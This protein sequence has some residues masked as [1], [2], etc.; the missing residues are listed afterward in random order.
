[1]ANTH[2][3]GD[4]VPAGATPRERQE[5]RDT[6]QPPERSRADDAARERAERAGGSMMTPGERSEPDDPN[7]DSEEGARDRDPADRIRSEP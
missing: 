6:T 5:R 7:D 3:P 2:Y 4:G 1:M